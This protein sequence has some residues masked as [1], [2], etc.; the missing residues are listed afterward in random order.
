MAKIKLLAVII[1]T[2]NQSTCLFYF[3][4]KD[5]SKCSYTLKILP[6][7]DKKVNTKTKAMQPLNTHI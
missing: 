2:V 5:H 3:V 4:L 1:I 7:W 6:K